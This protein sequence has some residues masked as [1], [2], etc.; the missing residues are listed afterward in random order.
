MRTKKT[1]FSGKGF[2][3]ALIASMVAVGVT[4]FFA[5]HRT[6]DVLKGNDTLNL[7]SQIEE[8]WGALQDANADQSGIEITS[9]EPRKSER[10]SSSSQKASNSTNN[11]KKQKASQT[12]VQPSFSM[13]LDG[14]ILN[15]FSQGELVKSKTLGD[16]RT[17]DGIDIAGK[18][19]TPVKAIAD[20]V[21][22][23]IKDDPLWGVTVIIKHGEYEAHYSGLN[24][25]VNVKKDQQVVVGDVMG[26]VGNTAISEIGEEEHI[27]LGIKK[28]GEWIDPMTLIKN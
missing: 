17:H 9:R 14:E 11:G 20:G 6:S 25:T 26:S 7:S 23:E 1:F 18:I 19:S 3:I 4:A 8:G 28:N 12:A 16:W 5:V 2:Y 27:H 24:T 22:S 10:S 15:T 13:P 21:V